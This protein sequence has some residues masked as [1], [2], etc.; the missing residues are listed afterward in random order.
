M[1]KTNKTP[2]TNEGMA[3]V[4]PALPAA[5]SRTAKASKSYLCLLEAPHTCVQERSPT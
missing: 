1:S 4:A 2:L 3:A 5:V